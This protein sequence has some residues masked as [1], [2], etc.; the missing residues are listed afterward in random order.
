MNY[1]AVMIVAVALFA[2]VYWFVSGK[3]YYVGPRVRAELIVGEVPGED[4]GGT[5]GFVK[6]EEVGGSGS[7]GG[8]GSEGEK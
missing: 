7:S 2:G 1:V 4:D 6:K 5:G 3:Y 8:S